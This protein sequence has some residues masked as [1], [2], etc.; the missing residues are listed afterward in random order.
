MELAPE[1]FRVR[2]SAVL[3]DG[4][5]VCGDR[6]GRWAGGRTRP[7]L[8]WR[9]WPG[10]PWGGPTWSMLRTRKIRRTCCTTACSRLGALGLQFRSPRG[11]RH[12]GKQRVVGGDDIRTYC[13]DHLCLPCE[14]FLI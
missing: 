1:S 10:S 11:T 13:K 14:S 5:G 2:V 6:E 7:T 12:R 9:W 4:D 3:R 8:V